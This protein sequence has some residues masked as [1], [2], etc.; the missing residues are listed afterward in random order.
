[1]PGVWVAIGV[2]IL[3]AVVGIIP[4]ARNI[5]GVLLFICSWGLGV[6]IWVWS[7]LIVTST[8]GIVTLYIANLFF[9]VG[10]IIVA[11]LALLFGGHWSMLL[12]LVVFGVIVIAMRLL[13]TAW[14]DS[15]S[16]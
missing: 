9:A 7:V 8:W 5:A 13:G 3:A 16:E 6:C 10:A 12:Q 11:I 2:A 15:R 14:V 4:A 1:M